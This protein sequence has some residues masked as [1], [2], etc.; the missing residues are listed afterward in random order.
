MRTR[1]QFGHGN[2]DL[3]GAA[4]GYLLVHGNINEQ[5]DSS[6]KYMTKIWLPLY[7]EVA[8]AAISMGKGE[9]VLLLEQ[10]ARTAAKS[11]DTMCVQRLQAFATFLRNILEVDYTP[12]PTSS[13]LEIG[14]SEVHQLD[15]NDA[16][17]N[18][19]VAIFGNVGPDASGMA[20]ALLYAEAQDLV[21][22]DSSFF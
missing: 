15:L 12:I 7:E 1:A 9:E 19:I 21:L 22:T 11:V 5:D 2:V 6:M 14:K 13:D 18:H 4:L 20:T 8:S 3:N 17:I 16:L 10:V